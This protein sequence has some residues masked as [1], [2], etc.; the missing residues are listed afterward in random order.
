MGNKWTKDQQNAISARE[1][2]LLVSAAAGSGKTSVLVQRVIERI[3]DQTHPCDADRLLVVTFT[4]AAAAEMKQ[5]IS[6]SISALL[7]KNPFDVRLQHQKLL[8]EKARI[9]TIHSFCADLLRENFFRL[10]ISPGFRIASEDEMT[11]LREQAVQEALE[12]L[13]AAAAESPGAEGLAELMGS[14]RDDRKL[15]QTVLQ[16]YDFIRSTAFPERW[17]G[18]K[19]AMY[20]MKQPLEVSPWGRILME[21]ARELLEYALSALR[22]A[23]DICEEDPD[24]R[25]AFQEALSTDSAGLKKCLVLAE[26]GDWDGLKDALDLFSPAKRKNLKKGVGEE[27]KKEADAVRD[28]VKELLKELKR[29][30]SMTSAQAGEEIRSQFDIV[31]A[32]HR[33]VLRFWELLDE[34]KKE[35][36]I[37]DYG[38]LEHFT[39]ELLVVPEEEG[40][41]RTAQAREMSEQ[42][43]EVMIDEY[44]DTNEAQDLIFSAVSREESNLFLVGDVKQSIYRFRQAMPELFMRRRKEYPLFDPEKRS[45]P[46]T[47]LLGS[48]FR[49]RAGVTDA[50]NF[51]FRQLM[52]RR[53][54]EV[55]YNREEELVAQAEYPPSPSPDAY[56]HMIDLAEKAPEE[57]NDILEARHIA[58]VIRQRLREGMTVTDH[59]QQRP[60]CYR[61]FCILL[62]S[63]AKHAPNYV[64]E[65]AAQGI[66]AWSNTQGG[67]FAAREITMTLSLL[68][69]LDNP[70]QDIPLMAVMMS[71]VYGFTPD[72]MA[73]IR[74]LSPSTGLY[75]ALK[76]C[77]ENG[78]IHGAEFLRDMEEFRLLAAAMPADRL[79]RYIYEKKNLPAIVRAMEGGEL[80]VPNLRLLVEYAQTYEAAG[81][82][83]L[84][85]FVRYLDRLQE[86]RADLAAASSGAENANVVRIMSIHHSKGLEFPV[87]FLAGCSIQ[88]NKRDLYAGLLVH[89][90][91]GIGMKRRDE[92]TL[93]KFRTAAYDA[94]QLA[95][96]R[97][98]LS[99]RLRVLYVA[100]TRAKEKL[101]MVGTVKKLESKIASLAIQ[102]EEGREA[103]PPFAVLQGKSFTD[104]LLLAAIRHPNGGALRAFLRGRHLE[105]LPA[106]PWEILI[107]R[108]EEGAEEKEKKGRILRAPSTKEMMEEIEQRLSYR[109]PYALLSRVPTKSGASSLAEKETQ[110]E[111]AALSR[112]AFLSS[113]GM[114]PAE[115]GIALHTFLQFA[116]Y[117]RAGENLQ[118]EIDRMVNQG[119]LTGEEGRAIDQ[120]R[121]GAFFH[122][123][124]A[125]RIFRALEGKKLYREVR[126]IMEVPARELDSSIPEDWEESVVIQGV[127]DCVLIE[128]ERVVI[129]DYKTDRVKEEGE[130]IERYARQLELYARA[131]ERY[132]QLPVTEHILYSFYLSREISIPVDGMKIKPD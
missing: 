110:E 122:S 17:L 25:E 89:P 74:L 97:G 39:L 69:V 9:S 33:V 30:F 58:G 5:R 76:R 70:M 121:L 96:E 37:L 47:I 80:R 35:K 98:E 16:L 68:R 118:N 38:D 93:A 11:L 20:R 60:A 102:L 28:S 13:Y 66:P 61:D 7:E 52:S 15:S 59:G 81:Y 71:P 75:P 127:A 3:T 108:P 104:W 29:Y 14:D 63:A 45:Y 90:V 54:G 113:H 56:L 4:K 62:S 111:Y 106:M 27:I 12:E 117:T 46:A 53:V 107:C 41:R 73:E 131:M 87:V 57:D 23:E 26:Q 24:V 130:L 19:L 83:G 124:L 88:F 50:V 101:Y 2:T 42:F 123:P 119:F 48:N 95:S 99:E 21:Y 18:E 132:F 6:D 92:Q 120:K 85:G 115:R 8:L 125:G 44:Q 129:I 32:L 10:G 100:L 103:V 105:A 65:L 94:V 67:F 51:I 86:Q 84:S 126:F 114:T 40:Y 82:H 22:T 116:D 78:M 34:R 31:A 55:E 1:G 128:N 112:P 77:E 72:E 91:F 43:E 64:K 79:L 49:S 36:N 109:Y